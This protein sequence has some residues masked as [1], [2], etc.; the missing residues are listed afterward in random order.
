M[1]PAARHTRRDGN[2]RV[3]SIVGRYLEHS[4]IYCFGEGEGELMYIS[5]ADFMTRNTQRRVETACP[6]YDA[7]VRAR[8]REIMDLCLA[9]NVKARELRPDGS[10][11]PAAGGA[12][13]VD[14]QLV[15]SERALAAEAAAG[16]AAAEKRAPGVISRLKRLLGQ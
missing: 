11:V 1:L 7:A 16:P 9:D 10:Y 13:R 2:I 14:A 6:I 5:S 4:R 3:V 12:G 8:L 15:Q